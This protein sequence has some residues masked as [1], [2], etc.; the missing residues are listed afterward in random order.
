MKK[1]GDRNDAYRIRDIDG[2]H[3][4]MAYLMNKR[5]L[6]VKSINELLGKLEGEKK[7][8]YDKD[9]MERLYIEYQNNEVNDRHDRERLEAEF[10][11]KNILVLGPGVTVKTRKK[12][13]LDFIEKNN[14]TVISINYVPELTKPDYVF[15][16][17][18]KRYVQLATKLSREKH[19]I[20]A[21]SNVTATVTGSFAYTLNFST[22]MDKDSEILDNSFIMFLKTPMDLN[23]KKVTLA[24]FDGYSS[25][26]INYYNENMEYESIKSK[27]DYLNRYTADFLK[28]NKNKLETEFITESRYLI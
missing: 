1:W 26:D 4:Y 6:S 25:T 24:G 27:A 15:I 12:E 21:T 16:S 11:D 22:L 23:V 5:T 18:S 10:K 2:L 13:I 14:P 17:N 20:I 28:A 8:L 19:T 9:Y 7:L 3:F